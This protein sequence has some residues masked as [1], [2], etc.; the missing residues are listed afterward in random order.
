[1]TEV[2]DQYFGNAAPLQKNNSVKLVMIE[3]VLHLA[4]TKHKQSIELVFCPARSFD[5]GRISVG[6]FSEST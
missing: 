6:E 4:K 1:M 5:L 3:L 2:A